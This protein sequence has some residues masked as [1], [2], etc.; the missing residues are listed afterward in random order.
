MQNSSTPV[1]LSSTPQYF[2][3]WNEKPLKPRDWSRKTYPRK[4]WK[5][6][7]SSY[8]LL[9]GHG[10]SKKNGNQSRNGFTETDD[11]NNSGHNA[12]ATSD[13]D[14][15]TGSN[16]SDYHAGIDHDDKNR[17]DVS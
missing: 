3:F 17:L 16:N 4:P 9:N 11:V 1:A 6:P 8:G 14:N 13:N 12:A 5:R 7:K 2:D 15:K 10:D